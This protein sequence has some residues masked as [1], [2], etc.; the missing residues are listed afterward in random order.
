MNKDNAKII[1]EETRMQLDAQFETRLSY[2][3]CWAQE[4]TS[5]QDTSDIT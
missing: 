2:Y 4:T 3:C 5:V 1:P